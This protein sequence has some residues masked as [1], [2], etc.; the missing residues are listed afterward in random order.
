MSE[1]VGPK[2]V[3]RDK[4]CP[5]IKRLKFL[6]SFYL[7]YTPLTAAKQLQLT[8]MLCMN[9]NP[10]IYFA[11]GR[12][13]WKTYWLIGKEGF[14]KP[15]PHAMTANSEPAVETLNIYYAS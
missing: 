9:L 15:L 7:E 11:Q 10:F 6:L 4:E 3:Q 13:F 8:E 12:G 5:M 1:I 14:N 2:F